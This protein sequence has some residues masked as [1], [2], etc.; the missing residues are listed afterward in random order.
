[1]SDANHDC[2]DHTDYS[3][4]KPASAPSSISNRPHIELDDKFSH[5][6]EAQCGCLLAHNDEGA[7]VIYLCQM[8]AAAPALRSALELIGK[9]LDPGESSP[10]GMADMLR[11]IG[12]IQAAALAGIGQEQAP[13]PF[14]VVELEGGLVQ[15]VYTNTPCEYMTVDL[16]TEGADPDDLRTIP[17]MDAAHVGRVFEC[18]LNPPLVERARSV[19]EI[20]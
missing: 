17:G 2:T 7:P 13:A 20:G 19:A 9:M 12:K 6:G 10:A 18:T 4:H 15:N 14:V 11:K 5:C 3:W 8:H 16:D 1:M